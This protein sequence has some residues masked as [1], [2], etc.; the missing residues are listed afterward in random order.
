MNVLPDLPERLG[1]IKADLLMH[2]LQNQQ[3]VAGILVALRKQLPSI[4]ASELVVRYPAVVTDLRADDIERQLQSL[5]CAM[6]LHFLRSG[7]CQAISRHHVGGW[8]QVL[9]IPVNSAIV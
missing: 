5:R 1:R 3:R 8:R 2:L 4:D 9:R 7:S 6:C